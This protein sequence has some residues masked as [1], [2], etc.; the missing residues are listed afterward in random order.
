MIPGFVDANR[1][2]EQGPMQELRHTFPG[3]R[4]I[5]A[6]KPPAADSLNLGTS[7]ASDAVRSGAV[8]SRSSVSG[9]MSLALIVS[10]A[11]LSQADIRADD[12]SREEFFRN[13]VYPLLESRCFECHSGS[14]ISES[15]PSEKAPSANTESA[16]DSALDR[17]K[18]GLVLS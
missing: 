17:K 6:E 3:D 15:S 2:G 1:E 16:A 4:R 14:A 9:L 11:V 12:E 7:Q 8:P 10:F 13:R 5:P 18:G